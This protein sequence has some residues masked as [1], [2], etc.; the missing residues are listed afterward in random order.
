MNLI[1]INE[2]N[3]T[4]IELLFNNILTIYEDVQG[5]KIFVNYDGKDFHIRTK[6]VNNDPMNIVDLSLQK[7]Y[8]KAINHLYSLDQRI[9]S[10][11]PKNWFFCFEYFPD[12]QPAHIEYNR[13]P[14]NNLILTGI[15]KGKKKK[16]F[17]YNLEEL[18]EFSDLLDVDVL[19]VIFHG[20]LNESQKKMIRYFL[21]TSYDDLE[22]I[23]DEENFSE[24]FY[25]LLDPTHTHSF[26]MEEGNFQNNIQRLIIRIGNDNYKFEILNPTYEKNSELVKTI[27]SDVYS[28]IILNF[29][30]FCSSIDIEK[31]NLS[32]ITRAAI[33]RDLICRLY[34][35]YMNE[36]SEEL[37]NFDID[38]P[39]F[40]SKEKFRVNVD[41]IQNTLT[42][43]YIN[44][45]RVFEYIFKCV[46][47]S[48]NKKKKKKVGVFNESNLELFNQFVEKIDEKLDFEI[49]RKK[50]S[51]I[52]KG[53]LMP[54]DKYLEIEIDKDAEGKTY[55]DL[56][57]EFIPDTVSKKKN[58]T[59]IKK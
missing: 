51:D 9:L 16:K 2:S 6:S 47:G 37:E 48:F 3:D 25:K 58:K 23:F 59:D 42:K 24:F 5:S 46:L 52:Q 39:T 21:K 1:T 7:Y 4:Y 14:K 30:S 56:Y 13:T 40:F 34:N 54:F 50:D 38:I 10:L 31:L 18:I 29:L 44:T 19:P 43:E 57:T 53:R 26:L 33:Y 35:M 45:N 15:I 11:I 28:V 8:N 55:P 49:G 27:F 12:I 20:K 36:N 32:G 22:Y 17:D 41:I